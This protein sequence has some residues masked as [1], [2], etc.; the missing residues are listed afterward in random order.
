MEEEKS[1]VHG[2]KSGWSPLTK[3]RSHS[4]VK[5]YVR[6]KRPSLILD[7]SFLFAEVISSKCLPSHHLLSC[8]GNVSS[9]RSGAGR[10]KKNGRRQKKKER[11]HQSPLTNKRPK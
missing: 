11:Q 3:F 10:H 7:L 2:L 4:Q 8:I 6:R 9:R 5:K 1:R